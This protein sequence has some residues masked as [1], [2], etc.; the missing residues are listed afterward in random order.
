MPPLRDYAPVCC[1][2][3]TDADSR[4]ESSS[5]ST[6]FL[7]LL[8][9]RLPWPSA[10]FGRSARDE[11]IL[12]DQD[13]S[14]SALDE[15]HLT[16]LLQQDEVFHWHQSG[17]VGASLPAQGQRGTRQTMSAGTPFPCHDREV[18]LH[19][20]SLPCASG[21]STIAGDPRGWRNCLARACSARLTVEPK[22]DSSRYAWPGG[23]K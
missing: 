18:V 3:R 22:A 2:S 8:V 6:A 20:E 21:C 11:Y 19:E 9:S 15:V 12:K 7:A 14:K 13:R 17:P 1:C 23:K 5:C 16:I 4:R 10:R